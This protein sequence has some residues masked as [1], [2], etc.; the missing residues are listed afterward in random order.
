[1]HAHDDFD[2]SSPSIQVLDTKWVFDL[3]INT[4][5]RMIEH[6]KSRIVANGQPQIL[7]FNCFDVHAPTVPM[8]EIKLLLAIAAFRDMELYHQMDT[9]TALSL[10]LLFSSLVK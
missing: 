10:R 8:C 2:R 7:G 5:T 1:M 6:F 3:K 4:A 9:T